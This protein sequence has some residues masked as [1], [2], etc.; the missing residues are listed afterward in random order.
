MPSRLLRPWGTGF[1]GKARGTLVAA[2]VALAGPAAAFDG[3]GYVALTGGQMSDNEWGDLF[4]DWGS[5]RARNATQLGAGA[6]REWAVGRIGFVG[7]E[8]QVL[9]H[10][11]EQDHFELTVP[12]F[13]RTPRVRY[14]AIPSIAYGLG[15]SM[16]T[17]RSETE[18]AR[19]GSS[20]R[21]LAHWFIEL[22]FGTDASTWRPYLRLHHRSDASGTF[23]ADTGSNAVLLGVRWSLRDLWR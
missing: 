2:A 19:T 21:T 7:V 3:R 18:I 9:K 23:N 15:L 11:G 10:F 8:A 22:E 13:I 6:S 1:C 5:V 20:A 4:D 16:A 17:A 12:L 14:R